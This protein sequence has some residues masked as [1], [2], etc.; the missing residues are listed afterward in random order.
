MH[1]SKLL[2]H[3]RQFSLPP[4]IG[5][6][7][8]P[9]S[10]P[11]QPGKRLHAQ[12]VSSASPTQ[13]EAESPEHKRT[14]RNQSPHTHD[15]AAVNNE[16]PE[17][18]ISPISHEHPSCTPI[19]RPTVGTMAKRKA[20]EARVARVL[21][22]GLTR[23]QLANRIVE[24]EDDGD[25]M[26]RRLDSLVQEVTDLKALVTQ[27]SEHA[28]QPAAPPAAP[29]GGQAASPL[30]EAPPVAEPNPARAPPAARGYAAAAAAAPAFPPAVLVA[31]EKAAQG[32]ADPKAARQQYLDAWSMMHNRKP[33]RPSQP[34]NAPS[35]AP[36]QSPRW[37]RQYFRWPAGRREPK[38]VWSA[39]HAM[40]FKCSAIYGFSFIGSDIFE[41]VVRSDYTRTLSRRLPEIPLLNIVYLPDY[42]PAAPAN[43]NA[44]QADRSKS[45][46]EMCATRC[47]V[48]L[49]SD[50]AHLQTLR[51]D[52]D[53]PE[54]QAKIERVTVRM[55]AY[56]ELFEKVAG[57]AW[58]PE[59]DKWVKEVA[60]ATGAA[61]SEGQS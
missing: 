28:P 46:A 5:T 61:A 49:T 55:A 20:L 54:R 30:A 6:P 43:V 38:H 35:G 33:S 57:R 14:R 19:S 15:N 22:K 13:S 31:A 40:R 16:F 1:T 7:R 3:Q 58:D 52:S 32:A 51:A 2:A 23:E 60:P 45:A 11:G 53:T 47:R 42:D 41:V 27:L 44:A 18:P 34:R 59:M 50:T 48:L 56:K 29:V 24:L 9:K 17:F 25:K 21:E 4:T 37:Q 12:I 8:S 39:L 26:S 10:P 36:N